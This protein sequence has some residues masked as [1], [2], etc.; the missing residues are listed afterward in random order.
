MALPSRLTDAPFTD[1][2]PAGEALPDDDGDQVPPVVVVV[3][4]APE[5]GWT[6]PEASRY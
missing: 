5:P 3:P 4:A 2:L 1:G 6:T